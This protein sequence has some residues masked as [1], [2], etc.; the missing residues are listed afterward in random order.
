MSAE[1]LGTLFLVLL[2]TGEKRPL[3][4]PPTGMG[5]TDPAISPDGRALVF[6]RIDPSSSM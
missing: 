5:D 2:E 1:Q 6:S 3:M 4:D